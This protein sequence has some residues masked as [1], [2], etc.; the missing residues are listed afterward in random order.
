MEN[1]ERLWLK[2]V[3]NECCPRTGV[4]EAIPRTAH[5]AVGASAVA[6]SVTSNEDIMIA[7]S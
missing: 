6:Q 1:V 7:H 4:H 2:G 5:T 3:S